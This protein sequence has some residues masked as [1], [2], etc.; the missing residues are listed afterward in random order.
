M[1]EQRILMRKCPKCGNSLV[2]RGIPMNQKTPESCPFDDVFI[3]EG[4]FCDSCD[5]WD[6]LCDE[7]SERAA[8]DECSAGCSR[9]LCRECMYTGGACR[10]CYAAELDEWGLDLDEIEARTPEFDALLTDLFDCGE[11]RVTKAA[12]IDLCHR[13]WEQLQDFSIA[14]YRLRNIELE[15]LRLHVDRLQR[16]CRFAEQV[17]EQKH[18]TKEMV[19]ALDRLCGELS[20]LYKTDLV[21]L[22]EASDEQDR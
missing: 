5:Y 11:K 22:G 16:V 21:P 14:L 1:C 4:A 10:M 12:L 2:V 8:V 19:E 18:G 20:A 9:A 17:A 13:G 15:E 6:V 3:H 7:C